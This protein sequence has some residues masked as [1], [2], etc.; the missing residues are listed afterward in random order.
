MLDSLPLDAPSRLA[1][2]KVHD[3]DAAVTSSLDGFHDDLIPFTKRDVLIPR[4]LH[5]IE[6]TPVVAEEAL[7]SFRRHSR[8]CNV[9]A[10]DGLLRRG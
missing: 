7:Q 4:V 8:G 10:V 1:L 2:S 3:L 9:V 6:G 5:P